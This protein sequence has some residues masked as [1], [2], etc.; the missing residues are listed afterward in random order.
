MGTLGYSSLDEKLSAKGYRFLSKI[1]SLSQEESKLLLK[2]M[3]FRKLLNANAFDF[4]VYRQFANKRTQIAEEIKKL[5][6]NL[7]LKIKN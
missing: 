6:E 2:K 7:I 4:S 3:G 5:K 1:P